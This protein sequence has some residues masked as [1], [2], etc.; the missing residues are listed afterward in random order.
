MKTITYIEPTKDVFL[1][2]VKYK[3]GEN[4]TFDYV[5]GGYKKEIE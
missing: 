1:A 5:V 4:K 2:S 3:T